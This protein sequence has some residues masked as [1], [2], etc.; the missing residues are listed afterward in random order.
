[1][2]FEYDLS[3]SESNKVKHGLDFDEAQKLWEGDYIGIPVKISSGEPRSLVI[4]E[5]GN[6]YWSAVVTMRGDATRIISVRRS[7]N[8]E[9]NI[10]KRH[11]G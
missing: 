10:Y 11:F 7:R 5:I 9:K 8:E 2:K 4:G 1:M 6:D 3:K